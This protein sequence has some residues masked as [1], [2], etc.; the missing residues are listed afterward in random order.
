M[1]FR[2][3]YGQS[4]ENVCAFCGKNAFSKNSQGVLTCSDHKNTSYDG[5]KCLC[6]TTVEIKEGKYGP[7]ALCPTC[8]IQKI[9]R[10]LEMQPDP[11][12]PKTSRAQTSVDAAVP[13][14]KSTKAA[15]GVDDMSDDD[16]LFA[17]FH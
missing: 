5:L 8:G 9:N 6:G 7:F 15:K 10:L 13:V 12:P 16:A 4:K 17:C 3:V 11:A 1:R 2:K 14:K